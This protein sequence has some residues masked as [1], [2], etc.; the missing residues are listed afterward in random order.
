MDLGIA[1]LRVVVTAGASG[2]GL[3][4]ARAF[5][6]E[7]ARVVVCDV[8]APAL[9]ALDSGLAGHVCDVSDRAAVDRFMHAALADLGGLDVL[10]NN[11]GIAGPTGRVDQ[12]APEDWDRTLAV[13]ITGH[14]N[15]TRLA[16]PALKA[17]AN[18]SIIG[19]SS[20][21]GRFGFPLRSPYAASKWAVVG[22]IKSLAMEL[23]EFGIRANAILPGAVDGPRIRSVFEHKARE[24]NQSVE[25]VQAQVLATTSLKRLIPPQHLA[26]VAVFLASPLGASI[27]GQAI[28][29]DG[30]TQMLV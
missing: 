10:V 26:T 13:D 2:I 11:A 6:K 29:V 5:A 16:V 22:F 24:R 17:S 23:G 9:D 20:A 18:P 15:V 27:S 12:I 1:G 30:D 8:D 3:E 28:S 7:G 21:A 4:I 25:E 19:L 14:F